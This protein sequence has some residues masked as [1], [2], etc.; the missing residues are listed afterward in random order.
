MKKT[1]I[2]NDTLWGLIAGIFILGFLLSWF[3][4][5]LYRTNQLNNLGA[6]VSAQA[7]AQH[8]TGGAEAA[9]ATFAEGCAK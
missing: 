6:C 5:G 2:D 1:I 7:Q 9:W 4:F 8:F 3:I